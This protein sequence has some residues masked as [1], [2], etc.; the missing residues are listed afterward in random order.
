MEGAPATSLYPGPAAA[1]TPP[2]GAFDAPPLMSP[3]YTDHT[4][5]RP[6]VDVHMAVYR[7]PV[8]AASVSTTTGRPVTPVAASRAVDAGGW[9]TVSG[10]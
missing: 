4:A 6:T 10:R 2:G 7:Q 3:P 9:T 5:S 8:D 1:T